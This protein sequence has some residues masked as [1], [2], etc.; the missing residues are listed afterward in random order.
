MRG[1]KYSSLILSLLFVLVITGCTVRTYSVTKDRVDQEIAGNRGYLSGDAPT[2]DQP[3]SKTRETYVTE[4]EFNLPWSK[5]AAAKK[6]AQEPVDEKTSKP[7]EDYEED[8]FA[9]DI[10]DEAEVEDTFTMYEIKKDDTLQKISKKF[11]GTYRKWK[12]IYDV[13]TDVIKDPNRI[14]PGTMIKVP[15]E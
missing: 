5:K 4:F 3:R 13:N 11:Y 1:R 9:E 15:Q 8:I 6:V 7:M 10:E 14:K 12:K 2:P